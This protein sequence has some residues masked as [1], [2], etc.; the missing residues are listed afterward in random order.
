MVLHMVFLEGN[1]HRENDRQVGP[2]TKEPIGHRVAVAE[3]DIVRDFVNGEHKHV[4][5]DA[6]QEVRQNSG[7]EVRE[8]KDL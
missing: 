4:V 8:V 2:H 3:D 1:R 5:D 6:T 7:P